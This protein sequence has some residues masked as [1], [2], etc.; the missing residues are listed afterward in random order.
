MM[1]NNVQVDEQRRNTT[2]LFEDPLKAATGSLTL[3]PPVQLSDNR[4]KL[5]LENL[6]SK[7]TTIDSGISLLT[8]IFHVQ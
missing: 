8:D 7:T 1:G 6:N 5:S 4:R 2:H 3:A